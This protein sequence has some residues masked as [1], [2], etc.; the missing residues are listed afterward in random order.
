MRAAIRFVLLAL[1]L[2]V[3]AMLSALTAMRLAIHGQEVTVPGLV[4][5]AP[6]DAERTAGGLGLQMSIERQYYSP[7]IPEGK[8][9]SQLPLPGTKV[10]RG[11]QGGGGETLGP[12]PGGGSG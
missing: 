2:I 3:V 10:R 4:G 9:M 5:M 1:V 12:A 6:A 8:I 11:G 7:Q